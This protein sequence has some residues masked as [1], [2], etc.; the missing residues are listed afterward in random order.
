MG[1]ALL[2]GHAA[3]EE[4]L[5]RHTVSAATKHAGKSSPR[6]WPRALT[7]PQW[8]CVQPQARR[9]SRTFPSQWGSK[10]SLRN[11]LNRSLSLVSLTSSRWVGCEVREKE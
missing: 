10:P 5:V 8:P 7:S 9:G 3:V 4:A 1:R 11:S 2:V 6:R